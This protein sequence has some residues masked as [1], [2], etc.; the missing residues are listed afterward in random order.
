MT[1][2]PDPSRPGHLAGLSP[3]LLN[4]G[5][6]RRGILKA[7]GLFGGA[8]TLTGGAAAAAQAAGGSQAG[9]AGQAAYVLPAGFSGTMADLK[10]V[11]ILM[12][13]NR[14]FDHYYGAM[15]GVRGFNDKQALRFPNGTDV[16]AQPNGSA[17]ARPKHVTTVAQTTTG[18]DHSYG[19]GTSAWNGGRYNN[20]VPAKSA[21]TMNYLTGD[22]IPWQWSL[23]SSY[24]LCDNYHCSVMGPTTPNRL[25]LWTGTSNGVTANGGETAGNRAWQTYPE[26]L[27]AAGVSWRVYV[28]NNSG[29]GWRGDYEDN[30]IRGFA[31]FT[32][33]A[34]NLADPV[35]TAPG[36]GLVW[37]ANS[38]PY[39]PDGLP[40]DD[41]DT[42]LDGVLREFIAACAPG[43]A[44][45]LP[46][47]SWVVAPYEWSE[48]PSANPEHGA[49]YTNR[50]LKA[51][52]SNPDIWNHTLLILN[53]DENDGYFDH[54]LPPFPETGTA[55]EYSGSTPIGYGARVPMT[56]VSPWTRGGW[57]NSE[58]FDHTSVIRFL[59]VWTASLGTPAKSTTITPWR[60]GISGDLTSAIDF[61]RPVLDT[62]ALPDTA[63]LVAIARAGGIIATQVPT[64]DKWADYPALRPR[65]LAF[66]PHGTFTE[67]RRTGKVTAALSLVGGPAGK[68][69]SLQVFPDKYRAFANTPYTVTAAAPRTHTWDATAYQG[70]YAFSVYGP[71]G[72]VRSH[73]GT[74]LPA[75]QNNAG[76]PRIEV[77]LVTGAQP[78]LAVTLHND[79]LRQVHYT[80][81]ANDFLGGTQD[82]WVAPGATTQVSWPTSDGY[83][84]LVL[85]ADTGNGWR[86]RYAGRI[87]TA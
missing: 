53:F 58:V 49:H 33:S 25:Y 80:L 12:Q 14:S 56:L 83:Y 67:D 75:G 64:G 29:D 32:P 34:A 76:V 28:D 43:A 59:E 79:G 18:L 37:R 40:D 65:P 30:P 8:A 54:V 9:P 73:A 27:Q 21:A 2:T 26:A 39:A 13:E 11:V 15:P 10:H 63:A 55:G 68:A 6:S 70:R 78:A 62:P 7:L 5:L 20:W 72:F 66:H 35:K 16:F 61:S 86:H 74:V 42:N 51:L 50:V 44:H 82:F 4:S 60:R 41:S 52:Q 85:T 81:T 38:F 17:V 1:S 77:D 3:E 71:D 24:T 22:E 84:D 45:P 19:G 36:T 57:V 69:V 23:A 31:T 87:A 47:V 48:H 46:Q